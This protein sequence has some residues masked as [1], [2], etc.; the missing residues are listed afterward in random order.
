[1][2]NSGTPIVATAAR[3]TYYVGYYC[4]QRPGAEVV[5]EAHRLTG[6]EHWLVEAQGRDR[7]DASAGQVPVQTAEIRYAGQRR[8][9]L[10][11]YWVDG[12][13]TADPFAAKLLQTK[14]AFLGGPASAAVIV[15]STPY[16][17]DA[18]AARTRLG[19]ALAAMA[20]LE[21]VLMRPVA[22]ASTAED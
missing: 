5:N 8:L 1:M 20:P 18:S 2:P 3:S 4:T 16:D 22:A 19:Q 9:V 13:F 21:H 6:D 12:R 11:W 10:V 15:A 7:L 17:T 14:A